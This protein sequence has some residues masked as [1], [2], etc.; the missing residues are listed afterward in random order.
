MAKVTVWDE[1]V[2]ND[3]LLGEGEFDVAACIEDTTTANTATVPIKDTDGKENGTVEIKVV[4][5]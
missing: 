5:S 2:D 4:F 3:D 1:D